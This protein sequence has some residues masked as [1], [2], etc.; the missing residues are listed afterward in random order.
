MEALATH[1]TTTE[2][3]ART[4]TAWLRWLPLAGAAYALLTLGGDLIVDAFPDENTPL[5]KLTSYYAAHHAQVGHGGQLMEAAAI[6]VALFGVA[7]ALRVRT[8]SPVAAAVILI[9]AATSCLAAAYEGATF[10]FLGENATESHMSPQALQAWHMSAAAFGTN[11]P[12]LV[13]VLGLVFAGRALPAW[14]VWSAVVLAVA[15]F[16]PFGFFAGMLML[17]WFVVAGI[18]LA[19]KPAAA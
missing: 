6:F 19:V 5:G 7:V 16:T 18:T 1:P 15:G 11:V 14:L 8:A 13:L 4:G 2:D 17:L 9:G 10:Q 3:R 12:A